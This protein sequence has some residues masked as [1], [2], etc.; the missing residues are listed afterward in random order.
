ML[1]GDIE[2]DIEKLKMLCLMTQE[3][4]SVLK[5]N[6]YEKKIFDVTKYK[7]TMD[8]FLSSLVIPKGN[9]ENDNRIC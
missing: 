4:R 9:G 3:E 1:S 8:Y 7:D 5:R 6:L 2:K